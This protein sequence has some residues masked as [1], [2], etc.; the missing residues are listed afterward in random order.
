MQESL[1]DTQEEYEN[2]GD[3][4]INQFCAQNGYHFEGE[5]GL[6]RFEKL[7]EMLGYESNGFR[8][9]SLIE[10]FLSDNSGAMEKIIEFISEMLD[11]P[12]NEW[13]ENL[14]E[15]LKEDDGDK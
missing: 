11:E 14:I 1:T 15:S 4:L 9:G 3:E 5:S 12:N 8:F 13:R 6:Q 10:V 7:I 2:S